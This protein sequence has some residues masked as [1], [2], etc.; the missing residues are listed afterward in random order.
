MYLFDLVCVDVWCGY[1]YCG[2]QV[3]DDFVFGCWFLDFGYGVVNF[4]CEIQFGVVEDF[5]VVLVCLLCFGYCLSNFVDQFGVLYGN[6]FDVFVVGV[7]YCVVEYWCGC[8]V[9]VDDGVFGVVQ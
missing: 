4:Q 6:V 7:E 5:G 9:D 2:G 8:V 3:E 1:F